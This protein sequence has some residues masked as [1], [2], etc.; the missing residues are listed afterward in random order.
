MAHT[1]T[2]L[3]THVIF[4]TRNRIPQIDQEV[5]QRLFSYMCGIVSEVKGET[6]IVGGTADHVHLLVRMPPAVSVAEVLRLVKTN[7]SRWVHETWTARRNFGWQ[8]GY[9][10]FSVSQSNITTVME[11]I[12]NQEEHHRRMSFQEELIACLKKQGIEFDERYIFE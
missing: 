12:A 10:A 2:Q 5:R 8:A 6:M 4:S 11:Y 1:F 7:S 3:L 9:G